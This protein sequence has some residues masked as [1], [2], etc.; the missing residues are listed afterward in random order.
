MLIE[1]DPTMIDLLETL[2]EMEGFDVVKL[3]QF[4][5][6]VADIKAEM[7]DLVL[8]DVHLNDADGLA[9]CADIRADEQVSN[10]KVVISSG[11]DMKFESKKAGADEFLLKPYMPDDLISLIKSILG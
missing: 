10:L 4:M 1:D 6:V 8:M 7:P 5:N 9:F 11:M 2:L 3:T